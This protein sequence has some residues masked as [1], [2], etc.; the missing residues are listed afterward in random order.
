MATGTT[1]TSTLKR[2]RVVELAL[3]GCH[4]AKP[5][6]PLDNNQMRDGVTVLNEILRE[7]DQEHTGL[8]ASL[9]ALAENHLFLSAGVYEYFSGD[10][11]ATDIQQIESASYRDVNGDDTPIKI[12]GHNE[13]ECLTP[14]NETGDPTHIV[15][16]KNRVLASQSVR[17]WPIPT[18]E[19]TTSVVEGSDALQYM[20]ILKH[21]SITDNKPITGSNYQMFWRQAGSG[22]SAW[23]ADTEYSNG[24]IIRIHYKRPLYEFT[25]A[26]ND[27]DLPTGWGNY[28]K[29]R[30]MVELSPEY[31]TT[32][33]ERG[34]FERQ[35]AK[36]AARL[37]PST[38]NP[39]K[40][41]HNRATYF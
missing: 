23:V 28:L 1:A 4:A 2:N 7:I 19:G 18:E 39:T 17:V 36:A 40:D 38:R 16:V 34:W 33:E 3:R 31:K 24:I 5:G 21:T 11:L 30:L 37:F 13:Y 15:L 9:W 14:K 10:G 32:V 20:C 12:I 6:Q 29:W 22:G 8:S 41:T 26:D 27:P 35:E 25:L